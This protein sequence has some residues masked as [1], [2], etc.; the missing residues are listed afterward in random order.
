MWFGNS[1]EEFISEETGKEFVVMKNRQGKV[2]GF[3]KLNYT[4][5]SSEQLR[6]AFETVTT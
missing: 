3:E 2:I 1:E 6:V 4:L 5:P